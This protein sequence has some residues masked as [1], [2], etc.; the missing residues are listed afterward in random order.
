MF[1]EG[2]SLSS[3]TPLAVPSAPITQNAAGGFLQVADIGD[4]QQAM[5]LQSQAALVF[6]TS[7]AFLVPSLSAWR[8]TWT[9]HACLFAV[10]SLLSAAQ[11]VCQMGAFPSSAMR[12]SDL[13]G[14]AIES[15][16]CPAA[17]ASSVAQLYQTWCCFC[18]LQMAWL[19][20]GPEDPQL[21]WLSL[22]GP[23][24]PRS[25]PVD[26]ILVA[27]VLPLVMLTVLHSNLSSGLGVQWQSML[28]T[29]VLLILGC[30]GFWWQRRQHA[31]NILLRL[32]FWQRLL[33][34][35]GLPALMRLWIFCI[36]AFRD[37]QVLHCMC[38]LVIASFSV[39]LLRAVLP[40]PTGSLGS[41]QSCARERQAALPP[42]WPTSVVDSSASNPSV[43][44]VLLCAP[45]LAAVPGT[46][47]LASFDWCQTGGMHIETMGL[48]ASCEP[49][50]Y[51]LG[52]VA[53][54][55]FAAG[56]AAFHLIDTAGAASIPWTQLARPLGQGDPRLA[57]R[58]RI[59]GKRFGCMLGCASS[60][61]G[62]AASLC[63]HDSG[64][65]HFLAMLLGMS[66]AIC[67]VAAMI[68]TVL[69]SDPAAVGY[70]FRRTFTLFV[71]MPSL[72]VHL[73]LLLL[74]QCLPKSAQLPRA[75]YVLSEQVAVVLFTSWPL[76]W[77]AELRE[78]S[79][80]K[81]SSA[82]AWPVTT[83]RFGAVIAGGCGAASKDA[84]TAASIG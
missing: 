13:G 7:L 12:D 35:G 24:E 57:Q 66:G 59:L 58:E 49:S 27:R 39:G 60:G 47:A 70:Q 48:A 14:V 9:W 77:A 68:I 64:V 34:H 42:S 83:W 36:V 23:R 15:F 74:G 32:K 8:T 51:F 6:V 46:I 54:H 28:V 65:Q 53:V 29:E 55:L 76:T 2:F 62:L 61:L 26:V 1:P 72:T 37:C 11:H 17:V 4:V 5:D 84:A 16:N 33:H 45:A 21:H 81:R 79:V 56:L 43:A 25:A 75:L 40:D 50:G 78:E 41:P 63:A 19:V 20:L 52:I 30:F 38:Q 44:H 82:F 69:S 18:F 80:R 3:N 67:L 31:A 10:L 22:Q 73:L 71:C